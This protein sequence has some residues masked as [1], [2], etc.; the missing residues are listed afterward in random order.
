M[1]DSFIVDAGRRFLRAVTRTT[2]DI[3]RHSPDCHRGSMDQNFPTDVDIYTHRNIDS[4][5]NV[6]AHPNSDA[7]HYSNVYNN[8]HSYF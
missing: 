7:N 5:D 1:E 2:S 8:C 3:Y 6:N 4:N